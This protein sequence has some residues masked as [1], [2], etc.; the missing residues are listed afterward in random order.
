MNTLKQ[1]MKASKVKQTDLCKP[2]KMGRNR[3]NSIV[4]GKIDPRLSEY[5]RIVNAIGYEV[6]IGK[7]V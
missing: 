7:T 2:L 6:V 4:N 3:L 5:T 1:I